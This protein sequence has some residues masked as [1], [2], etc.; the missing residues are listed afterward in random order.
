MAVSMSQLAP[1]R[2]WPTIRK[3]SRGLDGSWADRENHIVWLAYYHLASA[4]CLFSTAPAMISATKT[5]PKQKQ[6]SITP[7]YLLDEVV[8]CRLLKELA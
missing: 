4:M 3:A 8:K 1:T 2:T 5:P 7:L 6:R